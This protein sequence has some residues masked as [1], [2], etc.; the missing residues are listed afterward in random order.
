VSTTIRVSEATRDRIAALA[1]AEHRPMTVI[2]DQALDA[3][4][5]RVFFDS[6]N[7]TYRSLRDDAV[8]WAAI[9]SERS[10]ESVSWSDNDS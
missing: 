3:L 6:F 1:D 5:R 9:E 10:V 2:V 7:A 8:A 4:E